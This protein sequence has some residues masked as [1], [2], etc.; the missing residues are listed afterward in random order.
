MMTK[1]RKLP[2]EVEAEQFFPS[3]KPHPE[4]V[5]EHV[6]KCTERDGSRH[7]WLGWRIDTLEG[8]L[9][10]SPGDW[11]ITGVAGE[12]YPCKPA[13]FDAIYERVDQG[14]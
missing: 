2:I 12:R 4:G 8:P 6:Y 5:E 7:R 13:I 14:G 9:S 10:V 3:R 11:I 1:Y